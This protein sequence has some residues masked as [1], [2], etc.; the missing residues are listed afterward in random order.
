MKK[1]LLIIFVLTLSFA[2]YGKDNESLPRTEF[3]FP[4]I[5]EENKWDSQIIYDTINA[6][7]QGT[8]RWIVLTHPS[9]IGQMP[10][11][12]SQRQMLEH[13]F[14]VL[15]KIRLENNILDYKKK[16]IDQNWTGQMFIKKAIECVHQY[17]TLPD[18][19]NVM[20]NSTKKYLNTLEEKTQNLETF[21]KTLKEETLPESNDSPKESPDQQQEESNGIPE[22]IFQG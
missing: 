14:C 7:Y 12:M 15:D 5:L 11:P 4:K 20:D 8:L 3:G 1:S 22:T 18:F 6:C 10:G 21:R 17:K 19:F 13:C 9:L 16:V 2:G